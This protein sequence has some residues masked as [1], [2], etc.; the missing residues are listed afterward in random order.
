LAKTTASAVTPAA[1]VTF[2]NPTKLVNDTVSITDT[3]GNAT[4]ATYSATI[5]APT[6]ITY[7]KTVA[8][9]VG[10]CAPYSN[11]AAIP[12][13][14]ARA[15]VTVKACGPAVTGALTIGYWQNK[16]GQSIIT[17]GKA[18][19][20]VCLSASSLRQYLPFQDLSATASCATV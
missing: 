14:G 16:N 10:G 9:P 4:P 3:F 1:S 11:V 20:G 15:A 12:V 13:V 6:V 2:G 18:V 17:T 5:G 7:S 8:V 19:S